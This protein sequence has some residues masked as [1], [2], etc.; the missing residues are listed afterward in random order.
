MPEIESRY[1]A[2]KFQVSPAAAETKPFGCGSAVRS[3]A[4]E[5]AR[6]LAGGELPKP[7]VS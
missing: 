7:G 1:H 6:V 2:E 3:I 5:I 4:S